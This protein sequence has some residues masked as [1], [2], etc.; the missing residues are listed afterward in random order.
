MEP[1]TPLRRV[2]GTQLNNE[3]KNRTLQK[4]EAGWIMPQEGAGKAVFGDG[5][6]ESLPA[7]L[8]QEVA[9]F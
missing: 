4:P 6:G 8:G 1:S 3:N 5:G 9:L 2:F 7:P